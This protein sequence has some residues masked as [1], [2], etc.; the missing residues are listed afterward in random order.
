MIGHILSEHSRRR[1][2]IIWMFNLRGE[3]PIEDISNTGICEINLEKNQLNDKAVIEL[4]TFLK[5]DTWTKCIN[6]KG[7]RIKN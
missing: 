4:A 5:N 6:L 3:T 7:N 1:S 2:E